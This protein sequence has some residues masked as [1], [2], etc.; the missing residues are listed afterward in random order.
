[1]ETPPSNCLMRY[2]I[3][4]PLPPILHIVKPS[5]H[6][7]IDARPSSVHTPHFPTKRQPPL[8]FARASASHVLTRLYPIRI[9]DDIAS[10]SRLEK[11][12]LFSF[13]VVSNYC[14]STS[15][16]EK[17]VSWQSMKPGLR[18]M[19]PFTT[20]SIMTETGFNVACVIRS[21]FTRQA[22]A[23]ALSPLY[24]ASCR[25]LYICG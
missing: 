11:S 20:P 3:A 4:Q 9:Q 8:F 23:E 12:N 22:E 14:T 6:L 2:S 1:M 13:Q 16:L 17:P 21:S 5:P 7:K 10:L 25:A 18:F 24:L 15:I 19:T